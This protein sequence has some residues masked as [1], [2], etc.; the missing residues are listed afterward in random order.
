M[1]ALGKA[2]DTAKQKL[3]R[4]TTLLWGIKEIIATFIKKYES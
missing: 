2:Q 1:R 3:N 4:F